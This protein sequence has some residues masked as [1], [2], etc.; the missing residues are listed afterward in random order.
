MN[1]KQVIS[2]LLRENTGKHFLDSGGAYGRNWERNQL[3]ESFDNLPSHTVNFRYDYIDYTRNIY[4]FLVNCLEYDHNLTRS[5]MAINR[6]TANV[7][8][9]DYWNGL[10]KYSSWYELLEYWFKYHDYEIIHSDNIYNQENNISQV[11]QYWGFN[12]EL[13]FSNGDLYDISHIVLM[14]HNGCDVRGGYTSPIVFELTDDSFWLVADGYLFCENGH[15]WFTDDDYHWY[16]DGTSNDDLRLDKLEFIELDEIL[17]SEDYKLQLSK[18]LTIPERQLPMLDGY[19]PK[20]INP[21]KF[22]LAL[23]TNDGI[24]YCPVCAHIDGKL[25]ELSC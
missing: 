25:V 6:L 7:H 16:Y 4:H 24:G 10:D 9:P 8:Y 17:E 13:E 23:I 5:L 21:A 14:I 3:I 18:Q 2:E 11:F 20:V 12:P 15:S 22:P 19:N 1:T